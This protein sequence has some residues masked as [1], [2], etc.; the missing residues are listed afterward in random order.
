[1]NYS[2]YRH[3]YVIE[4]HIKKEIIT[5]EVIEDIK[6]EV[7]DLYPTDILHAWKSYFSLF[8]I[9]FYAE[10]RS[11][12]KLNFKELSENLRNDLRLTEHTASKEVD[13]D[14]VQNFG[15][16]SAWLAIYNKKQPNQS[17][18]LQLFVS[19]SYP[20]VSYGLFEYH[21]PNKYLTKQTVDMAAFSYRGMLEFLENSRGQILND[22]NPIHIWKFSPGTNAMYWEE[23]KKKGIASIGWGAR[24]YSGLTTLQIKKLDPNYFDEHIKSAGIISLMG[25]AKK[26]DVVYAFKGRKEVIGRGVIQKELQYNKEALVKDSDHH[27]YL[28]IAWDDDFAQ[29][30]LLKKM[31]SMDS[32]ADISERRQEIENNAYLHNSKDPDEE[33]GE[34]SGGKDNAA[35]NQI[36][37]GPPGTGKTY[38]TVDLALKIINTDLYIKEDRENNLNEYSKLLETGQVVFTTFHQSYGYEDFIEGIKVETVDGELT[39][40]IKPG[41]FKALCMTAN[42]HPANQYVIIIDEINRGNISKIFGELITLIEPDK[43]KD[44][45]EEISVKLPYSKEPFSVPNNVHIL[46]TMNTADASVAKLDVALRRRFDFIEMP[47]N[48]KLL[49]ENKLEDGE[50]IVVEGANLKNMLETMNRRIEILYDREHTIGHSFF[51]G[52]DCGDGIDKLA[53]IFQKNII[54]LLQEYFYEDWH[55]IQLVFRDVKDGNEKNEPQLICHQELNELEV[56]GYDHDEYE[57]QVEYWVT[58]EEKITPAMIR[59]VY[60]S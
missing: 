32:F 54:P 20:D 44:A 14:G 46:G 31:V 7:N 50:V 59:K 45:E 53:F 18:S 23:M 52:L 17:F 15:A 39:Y 47:P 6:E 56:L 11:D 3:L 30:G 9:F 35:T 27:N 26:G 57:D 51:M 28:R 4:W 10:I 38:H 60:A 25:N 8:Y 2:S 34:K 55:R 1:M 29:G 16:D 5:E 33:G 49:T 13:F 24:D 41:I 37:Y 40:P 42:N 48:P 43:R 36:L 21:N 12:I 58:S 22:N 19:F